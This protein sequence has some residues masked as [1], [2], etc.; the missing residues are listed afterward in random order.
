MTETFQILQKL[1]SK[2]DDKFLDLQ[3]TLKHSE[4]QFST[5]NEQ[6]VQWIEKM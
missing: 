3:K 5:Q 2:T 6:E 1:S 4:Q